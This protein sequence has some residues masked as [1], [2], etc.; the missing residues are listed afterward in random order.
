MHSNAIPPLRQHMETIAA[1]SLSHLSAVTRQKLL[2]DDLSVNAYPTSRGGFVYVGQ[3]MYRIP[4]EA[5][6]AEL[7]EVAEAAGVLWLLFDQ[8]A[9]MIDGL[10][11]FGELSPGT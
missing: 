1:L 9:A 5:D 4:A 8:D 6:L 2:T 3:P 7:F 10:P 11:T